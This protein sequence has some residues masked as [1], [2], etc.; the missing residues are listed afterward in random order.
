MTTT[1]GDPRPRANT[2]NISTTVMTSLS[3]VRAFASEW[4]EFA[5]TADAGNPFVHPDWL[6]PWAERFV[7]SNE[8]IWLLAARQDGRLIGVA[9]FYRHSWGPGLAHSMQLWGTGRHTRFIELPQFLLDPGDPRKAAR[10]LVSGLSAESRSWDWAYVSLPPQLWL[11]PDWL[12]KGGSI[13]IL[14]KMVR[15][16]VIRSIDGAA[17]PAMKRNVRESLRR[18]RNRLDRSYPGRWSIDSVTG[19]ADILRALPDL[20]A[21]HQARSAIIGKEAHRNS[22]TDK[23][24]ISFL[25][26]ALSASADR[27][28]ACIYRLLVEGRAV[29][30]LL[31]LR[32]AGSSYFLLS[33]MSEQFWDYSPVT[34]LQGRAIDDAIKLGHRQVNLSTG[35][36][37]AKT[38]WSENIVMSP[39]FVLVSGRPS[40]LGKFSAYWL[41]SA[42]A[43]VKRERSRHEVLSPPYR[44]RLVKLLPR[45]GPTDKRDQ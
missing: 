41:A 19:R 4:S 17:P 16:S 25:A 26:A 44:Q 38:R 7:R 15:A 30:A 5:Q 8:Q 39:E 18:G 34:L 13:I 21:L 23:A 43:E 31:V 42:A 9:P 22:L 6:V 3:E 40:S 32:G 29:A 14:M 20:T 35:P 28:G 37:R 36:D 33:G 27:G 1:S 45:G 10:A 11:Q 12:P 2:G 24:D